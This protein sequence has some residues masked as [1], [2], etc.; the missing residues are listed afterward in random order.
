MTK[1]VVFDLDQIKVIEKLLSF[2][3]ES[4]TVHLKVSDIQD[5]LK[6]GKKLIYKTAAI[7][8]AIL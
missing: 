8:N 1:D 5:F 6:F 3:A 7:K 4:A 2:V